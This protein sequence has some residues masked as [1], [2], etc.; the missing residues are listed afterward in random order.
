MSEPIK[1]LHT[2]IR[3]DYTISAGRDLGAFLEGIRDGKIL[4]KRCPECQKVYVPPR[5]GCPTCGCALGQTLQVEDTGTVTTFTIVRVAFEGQTQ[6]IPYAYGSIV[7]DGADSL[8]LHM[9]DGI[10]I[11]QVR[12]GLRVKAVW[13][14]LEKRGP[15]MES[16]LS[17]QPTG[18]P[19]AP[20]DSF[21]EH[22]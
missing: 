12:M 6:K 15:G 13:A 7:L 2:P 14:P 21:K 20:Y 16:I 17:F 9:I 18:E 5:G 1:T 8:F 4:G 3:L 22:L 11:D 10:A 19:D